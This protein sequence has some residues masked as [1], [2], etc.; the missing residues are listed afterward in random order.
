M[1]HKRDCLLKCV[2]FAML[3]LFGCSTSFDKK[4]HN[5]HRVKSRLLEKKIVDLAGKINL[6]VTDANVLHNEMEETK[7][8]NTIIQQKISGLEATVRNL[9]ERITTLSTPAKIPDIASPSAEAAPVTHDISVSDSSKPSDTPESGIQ[10]GEDTESRLAVAKGFWDAMNAKDIQSAKRY[11]TKESGDK[12]LITD[13][14]A[15]SK[16]TFG[17]VKTED[18]KTIIETAMQTYR[19]TTTSE[20]KMQTIL[21]EEDGQWKVDA[22]QTMVSMVGGAIGEKTQGIGRTMEQGLKKGAEEMG[23]A[24]AVDTQKGL[25]EMS[26]AS[27]AKSDVMP[28]KQEIAATSKGSEP[29]EREAFLKDNIVSLAEAEFPDN[30]GLQW[31][32]LGFE[33]KAHLT[34]VEVE[35]TPASIGYPRLKFAITFKNPETPRVIGTYC[36]KDGQYSLLSTKKN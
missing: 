4:A 13:T 19:G 29:A 27:D 2:C 22:G 8:S 21:V 6:V 30:K 1:S 34:Y 24:V 11:V 32:I 5:E 23:K 14:D 9:N 12:L 20:A 3:F 25:Q 35:P 16:V 26:Y 17:E 33:H 10:Q 15:S 7:T 28:P 18:N 31:K 36:F